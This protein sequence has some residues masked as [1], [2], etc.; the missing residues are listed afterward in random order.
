MDINQFS[1]KISDMKIFVNPVTHTKC[2]LWGQGKTEFKAFAK[3]NKANFAVMEVLADYFNVPFSAFLKLE[4]SNFVAI[5]L[6][7][8]FSYR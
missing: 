8:D 5:F 3:E 1:V 2:T 6:F 7:V 4:E